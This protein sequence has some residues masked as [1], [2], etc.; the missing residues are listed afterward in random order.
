[1]AWLGIPVY[2]QLVRHLLQIGEMRQPAS[3]ASSSRVTTE[4]S[5]S[6]TS[7][8]TMCWRPHAKGEIEAAYNLYTYWAER[9]A[10]LALWHENWPG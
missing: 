1:M 7:P 5:S 8:R 10:A 4:P 9:K 2:L 3:S 6:M